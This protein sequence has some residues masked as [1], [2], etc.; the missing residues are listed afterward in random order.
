[1]RRFLLFF[2]ILI[3]IASIMCGQNDYYRRQAQNYQREAEYYQRQ[4]AN[5]RR[6]ATNYLKQADNYQREV[7][8]YTKRDKW[9]VLR[10]K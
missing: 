2:L 9:N 3:N 10:V 1:M 7:A 6:E 4:A 8:Y 5:Y